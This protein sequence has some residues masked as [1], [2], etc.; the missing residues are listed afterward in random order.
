MKNTSAKKINL[1]KFDQG[2]GA[3]VGGPG[4]HFNVTIGDPNSTMILGLNTC[5]AGNQEIYNLATGDWLN[6]TFYNGN[7][8]DFTIYGMAPQIWEMAGGNAANLIIDLSYA[9]NGSRTRFTGRRLCHT[10]ISKYS[11]YNSTLT[12][13]TDNTAKVTALIV[14]ESHVIER[15]NTT[16]I[17]LNNLRPT[18]NGLFLLQYAGT[19]TPFYV[20]GWADSI[21]FNGVI[22]TGLGF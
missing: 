11:G 19:G 20:I 22:Q 21:Q 9:S 4:Y 17:R 16:I 15:A 13:T 8:N 5:L 1:M 3:I 12:V 6:V 14:N 7:P 10:Y 18:D 2:V